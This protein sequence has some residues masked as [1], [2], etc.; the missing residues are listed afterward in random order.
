[1]CAYLVQW[2]A[3][4]LEVPEMTV[5]MQDLTAGPPY[6]PRLVGLSTKLRLTGRRLSDSDNK[7][8]KSERVM[9]KKG[10]GWLVGCVE[11]YRPSQQFFSHVGTEPSLPG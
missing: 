4:D 7:V 6:I 1:M 11:A 5:K 2:G 10:F 3:D 9:K 8:T